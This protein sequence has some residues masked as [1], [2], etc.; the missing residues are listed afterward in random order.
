MQDVISLSR[1][2]VKSR[3][4]VSPVIAENQLAMVE[5]LIRKHLPRGTISRRDLQRKMNA[6]RYGVQLFNRALANLVETGEL[7]TEQSGKSIL[8]TR[9][10][11]PDE[12]S[13]SSVIN[14][15]DDSLAA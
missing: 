7:Q 4:H 10:A 8:Y 11:E 3:L 6:D 1:H 9:M 13:L 5:Q 15:D 12:C 2:Q 14:F